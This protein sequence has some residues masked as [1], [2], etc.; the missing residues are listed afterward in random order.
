[1]LLNSNILLYTGLTNMSTVDDSLPCR[2][3]GESLTVAQNSYAV[4]WAKGKE[5]N[6]V[7]G[8]VLSLQVL[9]SHLAVSYYA[10]L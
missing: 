7:F 10:K 4:L 8:L 2:L 6:L 1:M 5:L 9:V 3:G